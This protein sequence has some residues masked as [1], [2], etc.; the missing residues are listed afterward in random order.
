MGE[1]LKNLIVIESSGPE[2]VNLKWRRNLEMENS[3]D[4][5]IIFDFDLTLFD[6]KLDSEVMMQ[7]FRRATDSLGISPMIASFGSSFAAYRYLVD[8]R[9][10]EDPDRD[11][12]KRLLDSSM[13]AGEYEAFGRAVP[14][15]GITES[16]RLL[17]HMDFSI[18]IVSSNSIHLIESVSRRFRVRRFFDSVWGRESYGRAKPAPDKLG[19]CCRQLGCTR[20]I[21]VGDDPSDMDAARE[22][23]FVG[24][25]VIRVTDRLPTPSPADLKERGAS[26]IIWGV[27]DL[28]DIVEGLASGTSQ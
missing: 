2:R 12:I 20:A 22:A 9:L 3:I 10:L 18:G 24:V 7:H 25:A 14:Y 11:R 23:N 4:R 8:E 27:R 6:L 16:L 5:C 1:Y 13:A 17:K 26:E 28:P 19:G 21:Y 15:P